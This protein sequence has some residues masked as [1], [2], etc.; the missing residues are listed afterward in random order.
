VL[1]SK[2]QFFQKEFPALGVKRFVIYFDY[3]WSAFQR[4]V[5]LLRVFG[6]QSLEKVL[7]I[8][9]IEI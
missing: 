1:K 2:S 3:N 8:Y 6:I 4:F 9:R 7:N 5:S